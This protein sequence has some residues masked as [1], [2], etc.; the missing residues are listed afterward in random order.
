M[1]SV[2][3][4]FPCHSPSHA[5]ETALVRTVNGTSDPVP[6]SLSDLWAASDTGDGS[7]P[8]QG[9]HFQ[10]PLPQISCSLIALWEFLLS[11]AALNS[12]S[13]LI[14]S[15]RTQHPMP[16][17]QHDDMNVSLSHHTQH[18]SLTSSSP[19]PSPHSTACLCELQFHPSR[20]W[21]K[22]SDSQYFRNIFSRASWHVWISLAI[23]QLL[24]EVLSPSNSTTWARA[25]IPYACCPQVLNIGKCIFLK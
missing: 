14:T 21:S 19:H 8:C 7:P 13:M 15:L 18:S 1:F 2:S 22:I 16:R 25:T 9:S 23:I 10:P 12:N 6:G 11:Y 3:S 4:F 5:N 24:D 17:P 20:L